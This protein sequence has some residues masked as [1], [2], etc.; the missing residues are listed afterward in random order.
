MSA[1]AV[2]ELRAAFEEPFSA[3][4]R[5]AAHDRRTV[6]VSWPSV[7]VELVHAAGLRPVFARG[8]GAPTPA[9]DGVLEPD[10]FPNRLRQLVEAALT[11]RLAN[12]AAIVLPRS[13]DADYKCFLYLRELARRGD[14]TALP[15]VL[16]F[17]LLHSDGPDARAYNADRARDLSARLASLAGRPRRTDNLRD[18]VVRANRAR[19]AARR[20]ADLRHARPRIA[21]A[22]AVPLLGAFWQLE[23]ERYAALAGAAADSLAA[24]APLEGTRVLVAGAPIDGPALHAAVEAEGAVVVGELS[25]FG[26][27]GVSTD[28]ELA[29]D[30]LAVLAGHY[31]RESIDARLPVRSMMPKLDAVLRTVD[32]VVISQPSD[33]A[34][35]GW[36]YPRVRE[37]LAGRSIPHTVLTGD[38]SVGATQEDRT[39]IRALLERACGQRGT[40]GG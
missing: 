1:S 20:V 23:P 14:A 32:V 18:A 3:L 26:G 30:P 33:D 39:R 36:D 34:A 22:D 21:G 25:P 38:S 9:A 5:D 15:P 10:L 17:D 27:C 16:L 35:F 12:V 4:G 11:K 29:G 37:I 7:P 40:S 8:T 13:S 28:V 6:L 2:T 31:A 24:R 19:G